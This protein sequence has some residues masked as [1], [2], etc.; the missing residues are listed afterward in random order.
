MQV[1]LSFNWISCFM[2]SN[3]YD[4]PIELLQVLISNLNSCPDAIRHGDGRTVLS[5][6]A[7]KYSFKGGEDGREDGRKEGRRDDCRSWLW[8]PT[9]S[10]MCA[11]CMCLHGFSPGTS[12]LSPKKCN[13]R[14]TDG[15]CECEWPFVSVCLRS[16]HLKTTAT[17]SIHDKVDAWMESC[18]NEVN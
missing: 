11:V 12:S 9:G 14:L 5:K 18:P 2:S 15:R 7:L 16:S 3:L 4:L 13:I 17:G 8:F 6:D 10:F 1:I